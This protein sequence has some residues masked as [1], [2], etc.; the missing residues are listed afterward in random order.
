M[1][2]QNKLVF[3]VDDNAEFRES[4]AWM[5][6]G[7]G[8]K[9]TCFAGAAE[10]LESFKAVDLDTPCCVLL[11]VRMPGMS[12][13]DVHDAMLEKT[14]DLPVVYMTGHGDVPLAVEAMKKGAITFLEKPLQD[15]ALNTA[16][17]TAFSDDV[18]Q[19]RG[20]ALD[21]DTVAKFKESMATLTIREKQ[22]IDLVYE[23]LTNMNIGHELNISVKT[24]ELHRSR[25][26]NKL[27]ARTIPALVKLMAVCR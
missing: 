13:L 19:S 14:I 1:S 7:S 9:T 27:D 16:L 4:T 21:P 26:V 8:Y 2:S 3:V 25:A 18:Q 17:D 11:D 22:I 20:K 23:G 24:V 10:A 15:A 6:E 5:L 12:G